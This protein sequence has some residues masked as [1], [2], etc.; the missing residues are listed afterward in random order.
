MASLRQDSILFDKTL[1]CHAGGEL[2][3]ATGLV[4][5]TMSH[6]KV[7][8]IL[9]WLLRRFPRR[10]TPERARFTPGWRRSVLTILSSST[11]S[12]RLTFGRAATLLHPM[13]GW[14]YSPV[15]NAYHTIFT[16]NARRVCRDGSARST[17]CSQRYHCPLPTWRAHRY[18]SW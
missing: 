14:F 9:A 18:E 6:T 17:L 5:E 1:G 3:D 7:E 13:H 10:I 4:T 2:G 15:V 8:R 11:V 16:S 12:G